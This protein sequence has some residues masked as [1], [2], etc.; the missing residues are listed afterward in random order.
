MADDSADVLGRLPPG[1][2]LNGTYEIDS[3]IATGGM[4]EVYCGHVIETG[5]TVA[6][7]VIRPDMVGNEAALALFRKE[8]SALHRLNH[9]AIIRYFVVAIDPALRRPYFA[10]EFVDGEP[11]SDIL[12]RGPLDVEACHRL[13]DRLAAG[14]GA[15]HE[16]GIFHRDV[17]PDNIIVPGGDVTR[18]KIIDFGIAKSTVLGAATVIGDGFAGKYSYVSP[19]QLGL[20]GG[21]ITA[22]SDIYS[23]GLVIA[24]ASAGNAVDM[25]SNHAETIDRRRSVPPLAGVAP[26]LLPLLQAMLQPFPEDRPGSMAEIR[27]LA[28]QAMAEPTRSA[29]SGSAYPDET[30]LQ[31]APRLRGRLSAM[32]TAHR[33]EPR[34]WPRRALA[35]VLALALIGG[36]V[37]AGLYGWSV[38]NPSRERASPLDGDP[39][40]P[41]PRPGT[42]RPGLPQLLPSQPAQT[43]EDTVENPG[44]SA[45]ASLVPLSPA[46]PPSP[47]G[48]SPV[49]SD[50]QAPVATDLPSPG[51]PRPSI[52]IPVPDPVRPDPQ[53]NAGLSPPPR[54]DLPDPP[55]QDRVAEFVAGYPAAPCR[56]LDLRA[57]E[58]NR[59]D[60]EAFGTSVEPVDT[61]DAAFKTALGFEA[62]IQ[63][64]QIGEAQCPAVEFLRRVPGNRA[65]DA[66]FELQAF[67]LKPGQ[68][69]EGT[70]QGAGLRSVSALLVTDDGF[71]QSI[72]VRSGTGTRETLITIAAEAGGS[73]Q[74]RP[75]LVIVILSSQRPKALVFRGR[76]SAAQVFP[77]LGAELAVER[78]GV[79]ILRQ[80]FRIEG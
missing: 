55:R 56:F 33:T 24:E 60:I 47:A 46:A 61:F 80:Y 67:S 52:V 31:L 44:A 17:S 15:A 18:A 75:K 42:A 27:R 41:L 22:R 77:A 13:I 45:P 28:R 21:V 43:E 3:L 71:V 9:E 57:S 32:E 16:I 29:P 58:A 1:T 78:D 63:F 2:Q 73:A 70:I 48:P 7:K 6:I 12:K 40:L 35:G 64:R 76:A 20:Y 68:A 36:T 66:R 25:G 50:P 53:Q 14:L 11:L 79:T 49:A 37:S 4:G 34:R 54:S 8:A 62:Q 51:S 65:K 69:V 5:D 23:L 38:L 26:A 59:A 19:E 10:M 72:P 30:V 39:Y 74:K